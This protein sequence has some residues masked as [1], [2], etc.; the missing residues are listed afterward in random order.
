MH[1]SRLSP[2]ASIAHAERHI[3][4]VSHAFSVWLPQEAAIMLAERPIAV[5][6]V[7]QSMRRLCK[8]FRIVL[9]DEVV[10]RHFQ[11]CQ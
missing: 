1:V 7:F 8:G 6:F 9:R 5:T 4:C 3:D 10:R 11:V 2:Q